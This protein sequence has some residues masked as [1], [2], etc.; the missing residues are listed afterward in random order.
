MTP[1]RDLLLRLEHQGMKFRIDE[2]ILKCRSAPGV[3]TDSIRETIREHKAEFVRVLL[4]AQDAPEALP[5]VRP[6][7]PYAAGNRDDVAAYIARCTLCGG[8]RWGAV[9][10]PIPETL[11]SGE[12]ITTEA[13]GC[14]D[15]L[16]RP[17]G[18]PPPPVPDTI[19]ALPPGAI[20]SPCPQCKKPHRLFIPGS[21]QI[22]GEP[23]E[24]VLICGQCGNTELACPECKG[25]NIVVD[26][27]GPYRVD[28]RK[29]PGQPQPA[30]RGDPLPTSPSRHTLGETPPTFDCSD[31]GRND[32]REAIYS[33]SCRQC[34]HIAM[35]Q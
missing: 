13:W 10:P 28:C 31:C 18:P 16:D 24:P 26:A 12:Q 1:A 23:N 17:E 9:A 19:R 8:S 6:V 21:P 33:W 25:V 35:K 3:M 20:D 30:P 22:E 15:C 5:A 29:R 34:Q 32:W 4:N 14:L 7:R 2:G 11:P 27:I